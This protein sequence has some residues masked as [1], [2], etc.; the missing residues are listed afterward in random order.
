MSFVI[1]IYMIVILVILNTRLTTANNERLLAYCELVNYASD[2]S[3]DFEL[4]TKSLQVKKELFRPWEEQVA[5]WEYHTGEMRATV[6][7]IEKN[8]SPS[9]N[10]EFF[11]R[12][13]PLNMP[14]IYNVSALHSNITYYATNI[15][16]IQAGS[17]LPCPLTLKHTCCK[18]LQ[19]H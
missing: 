15:T 19:L 14:I 16:T 11:E 1:T 12:L 6:S 17:L 10:P 8:E 7:L 5:N 9:S 18:P 2:A 4:L 3:G 13:Y